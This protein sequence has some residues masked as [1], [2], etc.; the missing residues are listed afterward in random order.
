MLRT[1]I[2]D[3]VCSAYEFKNFRRKDF[4]PLF[5]DEAPYTDNTIAATGWGYLPAD[6]RAVLAALYGPAG[7]GA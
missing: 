3:L 1:I 2:G 5:H 7:Q 6:M 4:T